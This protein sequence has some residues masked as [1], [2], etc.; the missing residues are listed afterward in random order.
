MDFHTSTFTGIIHAYGGSHRDGQTATFTQNTANIRPSV[1][2]AAAGTAA[3][4][5][6]LVF[7]RRRRMS[8]SAPRA[9]SLFDGAMA[10]GG[11]E[12]VSGTPTVISAAV[13]FETLPSKADLEA[14]VR[15]K[16]L[17]FDVLGGRPVRGR[18]QPVRA[19]FD[20]K[21]HLLFHEVD[22]EADIERFVQDNAAEPLLNKEEGPWWEIHA[23]S[24]REPQAREILFFRVEH[25][26]ADG[27]ALLQILSSIATTAEGSPLP[28]AE[29]RR[30][31]KPAVS[32]CT[33]MCDFLGSFFKYATA[34]MGSFDTQLPIHPP[35]EA[36]KAGLQFSSTPA[37][38]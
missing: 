24:T 22:G 33:I 36:R 16:V 34:P 4:I 14:L 13:Y 31:A 29:Y 1:V 25:A 10:A 38:D 7:L 17:A 3:A 19:A 6:Y 35:A 23:V 37:R 2:A 28:V 18:W 5:A 30:P 32:P 26:C 20:L 15:D 12:L 9:L 8:T 27:I 21:R 11:S